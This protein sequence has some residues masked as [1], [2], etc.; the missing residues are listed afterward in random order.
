MTKIKNKLFILTLISF[1]FNS[2]SK[3]DIVEKGL[4]G[5]YA[6]I[7]YNH[8]DTNLFYNM[9]LNII[10]FNS[11]GT[12]KLPGIVDRQK[13]GVKEDSC[14]IGSWK[15][16]QKSNLFFVDISSNNQYFNTSFE[17]SFDENKERQT[18]QIELINDKIGLAGEKSYFDYRNN[19][20]LIKNLIEYTKR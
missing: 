6:L 9:T 19:Q 1:L 11:N 8:N 14:T 2:C 18:L 4:I 16:R 15:L 12:V 20:A 13:N 17:V 10:K 7:F 5:E 3:K